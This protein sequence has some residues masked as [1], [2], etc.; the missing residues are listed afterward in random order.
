MAMARSI[1]APVSHVSQVLN[2]SFHF[3]LEQAEGVNEY[4]G[5]TQ[6][7]SNFFLL[8]VQYARAGTPSLRRRLESQIQ[9]VIERRL[10]LKERLGVTASLSSEAQATFY[11]SWIYGA[12]H[13]MLSIEGFQTREAISRYLRLSQKRVGE[14][15]EFLVSLGLAVQ[16]ENGR[17]RIGT[18]RIHLGNNSPM[19]SKFHT[20][21]RMRAI[22]SLEDENTQ[23]NLHYSS[24]ITIS[25]ADV[26]R[27]KSQLV[28]YIDEIKTVV[29]ESK[30]EGVHCFSLDFFRL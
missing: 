30:E 25:E 11:S 28:R 29:R 5:H 24:A 16:S 27:I 3:T 4:F 1:G 23:A 6:D 20:N 13:V 14:I 12:I 7:E 18:T 8:L 19:I 17:Y 26:T 15:L 21:W 2:G 10:I 9:Q 22:R